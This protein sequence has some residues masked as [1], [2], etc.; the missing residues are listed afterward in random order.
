M[1]KKAFQEMM[2]VFSQTADSLVET[3]ID[4]EIRILSQP[5]LRTTSTDLNFVYLCAIR[6]IESCITRFADYQ[7]SYLVNLEEEVKE[8]MTDVAT[9]QDENVK[10]LGVS[11]PAEI[12]LMADISSEALEEISKGKKEWL[13]FITPHFEKLIQYLQE[14]LAKFESKLAKVSK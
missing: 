14:H 10:E 8:D 6:R 7:V 11:D 13:E 2:V 3:F 4:W 1:G 12:K 9:T 5:K